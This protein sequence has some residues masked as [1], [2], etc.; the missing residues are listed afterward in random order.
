[1][2][3]QFVSF[4]STIFQLTHPS[5]MVTR[6]EM[7][8]HRTESASQK[9]LSIKG[10]YTYVK[11]NYTLSR[12]S[13][14]AFTQVSSDPSTV[15]RPEFVFKGKGI[16]THLSPPDGIKYY[17]APKGSYRLGQMLATI[18]NLPSR[19]NLF[20]RRI[21]CIYVLDDYS[22]HLMPEVKSALPKRGYAC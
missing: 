12:E 16:R 13:V 4:F 5:L 8:L 17:W 6:S 15:V 11:D 10:C 21:Y 18:F 1:M 14:T 20:T 9:T 22:G 7:P 19:H 2:C 3:E